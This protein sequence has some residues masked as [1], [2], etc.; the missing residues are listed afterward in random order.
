MRGEQPFSIDARIY[1]CIANIY[2]CDMTMPPMRFMVAHDNTVRRH[3]AIHR[4]ELFDFVLRQFEP[5]T[6]STHSMSAQIIR[7]H[8]RRP[9]RIPH[10]SSEGR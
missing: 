5:L 10:A 6:F 4:A 3:N 8:G 2:F 1:A 7:F 9:H